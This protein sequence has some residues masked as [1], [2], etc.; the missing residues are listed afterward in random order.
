MVFYRKYR[1]QN[2][3]ELDSKNA[4]ESL[5]SIFSSKSDIHA[6]L[7]T[8]PKGL[9]KTS[10]ARIVAK[11]LNCERKQLTGDKSHVT[12]GGQRSNVKGQM[13]NI[14][15]CNKCSQCVSI[16]NGTN[17]DV[18]EIDG[19]S[20]RGIGE[21]RDLKERIKLSPASARKK[22][23]I[24]DEVHMLTPEAFDA[25][26][27]TLEEPPAH[28]VF[29]LC[30]TEPQ[31]IPATIASRCFLV[32]FSKATPEEIA[33]SLER[34]A[35]GEKLKVEKDAFLEIAEHADGSFRD[36]AKIFEEISI[37][38][39]SGKITREEVARKYQTKDI[40][41]Y[42]ALLLAAI[43]DENL[44]DAFD[45]IA[46]VK[47]QGVDAKYFLERII[48]LIHK[49]LLVNIGIEKNEEKFELSI[50]EVKRMA[51]AFN[52]AYSEIKYSPFPELPLEIAVVE[53]VEDSGR[54]PHVADDARPT[55]SEN[56]SNSRSLSQSL[57]SSS[58]HKN[59]RPALG[60]SA[61]GQAPSVYTKSSS[62][63]T[64]MS[65]RDG[66]PDKFLSE[67]IEEIKPYNHSLAG[68]LRGC[69]LEK[70]NPPDIIFKTK[71]KFHK[72]RLEEGKSIRIIEDLAGQLTGKKVRI[73][74][75]LKTV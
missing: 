4:R 69:T 62:R 6:F 27:K 74:I 35:K 23:Y 30:T 33:R 56:H 72:E 67:L 19:A 70:F 8:G 36:A 71:Y 65:S 26:L 53:I 37:G 54:L 58:I 64:A 68:V 31:K 10:A 48:F 51:K 11:V 63:Q 47:K 32:S 20:N 18:I 41:R 39:G 49:F 73:Q 34:I 1:P 12:K 40:D 5:L 55:S 57:S 38:S 42:T 22:V 44:K 9:G 60:S 2:L 13:S 46:K 28:V 61:S 50:P 21:I 24:I 75:Q 3:E 29:V 59:T 16:T 45:I 52:N 66:S 17:M 14:E 25:L 7:F 43:K 15:P